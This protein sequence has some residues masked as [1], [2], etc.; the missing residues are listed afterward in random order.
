[1]TEGEQGVKKAFQKIYD[2]MQESFRKL[3]E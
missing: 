2:E 1:M 3:E